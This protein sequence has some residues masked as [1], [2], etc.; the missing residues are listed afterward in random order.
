M[1]RL[2][3]CVASPWITLP[4]EVMLSS[5]L[6]I[7]TTGYLLIDLSI[8]LVAGIK[9]VGSQSKPAVTSNPSPYRRLVVFSIKLSILAAEIP[10]GIETTALR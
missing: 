8:P 5:T 4:L 2:E 10:P 1:R 6:T 7:G 9:Q 3:E